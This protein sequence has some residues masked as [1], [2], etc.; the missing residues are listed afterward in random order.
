[1]ANILAIV[2]RPNVGKSTLFNRLVEQ[3][4]A[5]VHDESGVTRDRHY[6]SAIWNGKTFT[7]IDTGGYVKE[8]HDRFDSAIREQV[9]IALEEAAV[10]LFMLDVETGLTGLDKD[11]ADVLR[12]TQKPVFLVAN[13]ADNHER[14]FMIG[15]FYELGMGE[16]FP[17]SSI[18]GSGTGDLLDQVVEHFSEDPNPD[19]S[20]LPRLAVVGRPNA[21][22]SS[23]VNALLNKQRSI[24]DDL[25]GTTRDTI[26]AEYNFYQKKFILTDTAGIRRKSRVKEN[27]EF[28]SV[29][30]ALKAIEKSDVCLVMVDA[31]RGVEAQD[32]SIIHYANR[33]KKGVL[34]MINKW[35][36]VEKETMTAERMRKEIA[37]R[38]APNTHIPIVFTSVLAKQRIFKAIEQA[39]GIAEERKRKFSTSKL[40][41]LLLPEIERNPPPVYRGKKIRIKYVTQV[42]GKYPIFAF[43]CNFP[44]HVKAPYK[45]FLENKIRQH[46]GLSGVPITILLKQ[47]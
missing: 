6:G 46:F 2:G 42:T 5:I 45:R 17:I 35:D 41:E 40:N 16:V 32:L 25:A 37:D 10:V 1:M 19:S 18:N 44:K 14:A 33:F 29:L 13:K 15:D 4:E 9:N 20:G 34:I 38:L 22:K 23:L 21:G 27:V 36:L 39:I 8:G 24:V 43:F 3:R 7:V 31:T 47:K 12:R 30:R 28:Y 11:F 26:D